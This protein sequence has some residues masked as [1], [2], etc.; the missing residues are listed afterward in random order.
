M[1]EYPNGTK[2]RRVGKNY[3]EEVTDKHVTSNRAGEVV[4]IR[5]CA[6]HIF[7]GQVVT[8]VDVVPVTVARGIDNLR[9]NPLKEG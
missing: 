4:K 2:F 8:D 7:C 9:R 1:T 6:T 3:L 5:Y